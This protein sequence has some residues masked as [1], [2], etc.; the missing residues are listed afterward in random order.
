MG[1]SRFPGKPLAKALGL[2][3][4]VHIAKRCL[5]SANLDY[6]GVATCD[7]EIQEVCEQ[8][9]IP[10]LM[11]SDRHERCTDRVSEA[12]EKLNFELNSDDFV[13]MVQ[14][15]EIL[16]AP[17][18]IN[19]VVNDYEKNR[20]PAVNLLSRI[21]TA[22]DYEDPN[23]VKVVSGPNQRALYFSRAP[24]P[25]TYRDKEAL[26]YQQTGLIGFSKKFLKEFSDLPQTP[27]EK[28]ESID[29]LR[30]LEHG[31]PVRVVYTD[32][33]TIAIDVP[34]DLVRATKILEND[35]FI[36]KYA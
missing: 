21:Y 9:D 20:S 18:M 34:S 7:K 26:V 22:Q 10:V 5:L 36:K 4:I 8:H 13:L 19:S 3:V 33:E 31:L 11:T 6:V 32:T 28:V 16:V 30:V 14:G 27:L 23:V 35:L 1:S 2:P 29:M 25:S 12:I 17:D 15:D 24:I